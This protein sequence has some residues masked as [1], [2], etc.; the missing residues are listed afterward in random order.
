MAQ[1]D[2]NF[3]AYSSKVSGAHVLLAHQ[4]CQLAFRPAGGRALVYVQYGLGGAGREE[5]GGSV[6]LAVSSFRCPLSGP[7]GIAFSFV[8]RHESYSNL[9]RYDK[10]NQN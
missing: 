10:I 7:F 4:S 6:T 9:K 5:S 8:T 1:L 3:D 2:H